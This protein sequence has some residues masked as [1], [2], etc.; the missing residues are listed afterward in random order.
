[1]L[2]FLAVAAM[3]CSVQAAA[4]TAPTKGTAPPGA[5]VTAQPSQVAEVAAM[6]AREVKKGG[7]TPY[8]YSMF[9]KMLE[10]AGKVDKGEIT[11]DTM[12]ALMV[13]HKGK[14]DELVKT[15]QAQQQR[16]VQQQYTD[17]QREVERQQAEDERAKKARILQMLQNMQKPAPNINCTTTVW[18]DT[19]RTNCR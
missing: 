19:A 1:M 4:Q 16:Q 10:L 11:Q 17:A 6:Y 14:L 15:Q 3:L 18:G 13:I 12:N 7:M 8:D 5:Q 2:R 9:D